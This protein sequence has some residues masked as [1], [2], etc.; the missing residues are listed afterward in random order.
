MSRSETDAVVAGGGLVGLP[1]ACELRRRGIDCRMS[2]RS[3]SRRSTRRR[4]V[5]SPYALSVRGRLR[6]YDVVCEGDRLVM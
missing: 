1:A 5:S 6:A 2:T 4:S 3:T